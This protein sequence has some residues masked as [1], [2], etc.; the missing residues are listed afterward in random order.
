MSDINKMSFKQLRE[1]VQLLR[2]ELA[3]FKR[4]YEDIIYNLDNDNFSGSL[5]KEKEGMKTSIEQTEE[6]ITLHAEKIKKNE[7]NVA[8]LKVTADK[9]STEVTSVKQDVATNKTLIEQTEESIMST[10]SSVFNEI[11]KVNSKTAMTDPGKIYT[12]D[13]VNYHYNR[14]TEKWEPIEGNS[15][16]SSFIQTID[17]FE[18]SG[19][20]KISGDAIVGG[21][22]SGASLKNIT[23]THKL[24]MSTDNDAEYGTFRLYNNDYETVP[25]FSIYDNTLGHISLK[26]AGVGFLGATV[27]GGVTVEPYGTWDFERCIVK[28][29]DG[30][31]KFA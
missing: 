24:V 16:A 23:G 29:I 9:I 21:A 30:I 28:G 1:E 10:V 17:G 19:D 26:A 12:L 27:S 22:I 6:S 5:I 20:V 14:I 11:T 3:I 2:D 4:K 31:A 13:D 18:L 7:Q 8:N 25:Y 15:I